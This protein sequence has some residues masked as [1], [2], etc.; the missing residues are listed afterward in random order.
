MG[1]DDAASVGS[2][3]GGEADL[4]G[5]GASSSTR[6]F[7]VR[8]L[9][10]H[11]N[12]YRITS[13]RL[14]RPCI[15]RLP[16]PLALALA[17]GVD[18]LPGSAAGYGY[19][20][21]LSPLAAGVVEGG[22]QLVTSVGTV[23]AAGSVPS[24]PNAVFAGLAARTPYTH[25]VYAVSQTFI[26]RPPAPVSSWGTGAEMGEA[27]GFE[28]S[29]IP[30]A[31]PAWLLAVATA[32]AGACWARVPL[33]AA[34][35]SLGLSQKQAAAAYA[36]SVARANE[37]L[38]GR[39]S[40]PPLAGDGICQAAFAARTP[41][42]ASVMLFFTGA[43]TPVMGEVARTGKPEPCMWQVALQVRTDDARVRAVL[44]AEAGELVH[45][46]FCGRLALLSHGHS[47]SPLLVLQRAG[48]L[49]PTRSAAS[50]AG[51]TPLPVA[52]VLAAQDASDGQGPRVAAEA[53]ALPVF[54]LQRFA[55]NGEQ[56]VDAAEVVDADTLAAAEGVDALVLR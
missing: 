3:G 47:P 33:P 49:T 23:A 22:G 2:G 43:L 54:Q 18:L 26:A 45:S 31:S 39:R 38:G 6:P 25:H 24:L 32:G 27:H 7:H 28:G 12:A 8:R 36:M 14:L 29:A 46:L 44:A 35:P 21:L 34:P 41:A 11:G 55:R 10:M 9:E 30:L 50:G 37:G 13:T 56:A 16:S 17:L 20:G 15:S 5:E 4:D 1:D 52:A 48:I 40:F 53:D 19:A 51:A 42:G